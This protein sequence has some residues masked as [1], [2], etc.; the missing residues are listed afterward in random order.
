M[1]NHYDRNSR[2]GTTAV[3]APASDDQSVGNGLRVE[4]E[5]KVLSASSHHH[6]QL[7]RMDRRTK[8]SAANLAVA[9]TSDQ[10]DADHPEQR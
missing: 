2:H 10:D 7:P 8:R 5:S 3:K 9:E 6:Y 1:N 4:T